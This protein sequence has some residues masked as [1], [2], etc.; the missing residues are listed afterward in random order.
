MHDASDILLSLGRYYIETS[1]MIKLVSNIMQVM[2]F[3]VW[4]WMRIIV[5]PVCLLAN[6]Y[7]NRPTVKD[8]WYIISFEYNF[9]FSK[10]IVL[11]GMHLFWTYFLIKIALKTVTGKKKPLI[12]IHDKKY[13]VGRE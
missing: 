5:F 3:M 13:K 6:V 7:I 8:E 1:N 2:L 4:N 12:N 9:L 11:Y 10:T